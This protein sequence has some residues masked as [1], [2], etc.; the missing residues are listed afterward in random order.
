MYFGVLMFCESPCSA[1]ENAI[2][3]YI[4]EDP[5]ELW[6]NY[7]CW[8]E[9]NAAL[10]TENCFEAILGKCLSMYEYKENFKQDTRMVQLWM[11]YV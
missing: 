1:W 7:I 11:K 5:L 9:H 2:D 10:D 6:F 8:Y 4:G 3:A